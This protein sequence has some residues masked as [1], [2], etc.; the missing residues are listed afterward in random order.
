MVGLFRKR[1]IVVGQKHEPMGALRDNLALDAR[2]ASC[3]ELADAAY[4]PFLDKSSL[5][6]G[7]T[8][9][10]LCDPAQFQMRDRADSYFRCV[11]QVRYIYERTTWPLAAFFYIEHH[12]TKLLTPIIKA[13]K[14]RRFMCQT[15]VWFTRRTEDTFV[16]LNDTPMYVSDEKD[17]T[18][19]TFNELGL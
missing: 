13:M 18:G 17:V 1:R 2:L 3:I 19:M 5:S 11:S 14:D 8:A 6:D 15:V 4:L 16:V 9:T 12:E 7:L 10:Y